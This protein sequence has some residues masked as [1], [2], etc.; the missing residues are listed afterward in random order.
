V[1]RN[2]KSGSVL[3]LMAMTLMIVAGVAAVA[4][5]LTSIY[6]ARNQGE[7]EA[8]PVALAAVLELDATTDGLERARQTAQRLPAAVIEFTRDPKGPWETDPKQAAGYRMVR[9]TMRRELP[10]YFAGVFSKQ[11]RST[12]VRTA[13]IA[14]QREADEPRRWAVRAGT[15]LEPGRR[16]PLEPLQP[17]YPEAL[18]DRFLQDTDTYSSTYAAYASGGRGNGR[19]LIAADIRG[20][21]GRNSVAAFFLLGPLPEAEFAG[22]YLQGGRRRAAA[23][24]GYW[25]AALLP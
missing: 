15:P 4:F 23:G 12:I 19:R 22:A 16:Y 3:I 25:V 11:Q 6:T 14:E 5:D 2:S 1:N 9:V 21:D 8:A 18:A 10:L 24:S 20:T 7:S 17:A 13:V